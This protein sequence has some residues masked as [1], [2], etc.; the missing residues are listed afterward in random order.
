MASRAINPNEV[1]RKNSLIQ[2]PLVKAGD[3]ILIVYESPNLKLT[4]HGVSLE[5]GISGERIQVTNLESRNMVYATIKDSKHVLV[6]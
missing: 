2:P 1:I 6:N 4:A 3:R 5:E